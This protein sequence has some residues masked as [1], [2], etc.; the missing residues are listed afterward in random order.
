MGKNMDGGE[1]STDKLLA[2]EYESYSSN[3]QVI[4]GRDREWT[5]WGREPHY[6]EE[7]YY[8]YWWTE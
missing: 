3:R 1:K 7:I 2:K 5:R 4:R 8:E 6:Q